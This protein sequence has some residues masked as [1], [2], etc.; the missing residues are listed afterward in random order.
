VLSKSCRWLAVVCLRASEHLALEKGHQLTG[1]S[2]G[3]F[4]LRLAHTR[5]LVIGDVAQVHDTGQCPSKVGGHE[6]PSPDKELDKVTM[7][8]FVGPF[9]PSDPP[10]L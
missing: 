8:A 4:G 2:D 10:T 6:L 9:T 7:H 5:L 1:A 3:P